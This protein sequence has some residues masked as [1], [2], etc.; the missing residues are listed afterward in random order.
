MKKIV[1]KAK[2]APKKVARVTKAPKKVARVTKKAP[3][4]APKKRKVVTQ[5]EGKR[6]MPLDPTLLALLTQAANLNKEEK[7]QRL[8]ENLEIPAKDFQKWYAIVVTDGGAYMVDTVTFVDRK[9]TRFGGHLIVDFKP[10]RIVAPVRLNALVVFDAQLRCLGIQ[11][12][13]GDN[14]VV[15]DIIDFNYTLAF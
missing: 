14:G 13:T 9:S 1:K 7:I 5:F 6:P 11:H 3:K 15:G 4:K 12:F 10:M 2:K 8:L